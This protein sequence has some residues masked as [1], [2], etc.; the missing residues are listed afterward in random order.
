[1]LTSRFV[2]ALTAFCWWI[3][4]SIPGAHA[5]TP[6]MDARRAKYR[7]GWDAIAAERW[8]DAYAKF[9]DLWEE[10]PTYDVALNLGQVELNLG[11]YREAA[12][13]FAF[14]IRHMPPGEKQSLLEK[15]NQL[16]AKAK[17][18]VGAIT[19]VIHPP[20]AEVWLNGTRV[21]GAPLY[22]DL[23][24]EPGTHKIVATLAG[25]EASER[26]L[27]ASAGEG[28]ALTLELKPQVFAGDPDESAPAASQSSSEYLVSPH[29]LDSH[30]QRRTAQ[31]PLFVGAG[32]TAT[33]LGVGVAYTLSADTARSRAESLRVPGDANACGPGTG[34]VTECRRLRE[35]NEQVSRRSNTATAGFVTAGVFGVATLGYWLLTH[36]K[37]SEPSRTAWFRPAGY[38]APGVGAVWLEGAF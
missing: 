28:L 21:G 3:T 27:Q 18:H 2:L 1:M 14:G 38:V 29:S 34:L 9:R 7:Q 37:G 35:A 10:S 4:T 33:G 25:F 22:T 19:L 11:R 5:E 12:E 30:D 20:G 15:S 32:L 17:Q 8:E 31:W 6:D 36:G 24:V 16:L 13:H 26:V 23:F